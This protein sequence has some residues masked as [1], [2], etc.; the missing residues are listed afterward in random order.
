M[1]WQTIALIIL[2]TA[3]LGV[4]LWLMI[5]DV[6]DNGWIVFGG[7][8]CAVLIYGLAIFNHDREETNACHARGGQITGT[9]RYETTYV[10]VGKV[11][12][13]I[14]DEITECRVGAA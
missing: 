2:A 7:C 10:M 13:P 5:S 8:A 12:M 1:S 14:T 11:L 4:S 3:V 9:G 6:T